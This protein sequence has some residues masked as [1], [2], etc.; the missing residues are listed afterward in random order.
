MRYNDISVYNS[1]A[2]SRRRTQRENEKLSSIK[3]KLFVRIGLRKVQITIFF[4]LGPRFN[5][6]KLII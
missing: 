1:F 4:I 6:N 3:S 5:Q 2:V